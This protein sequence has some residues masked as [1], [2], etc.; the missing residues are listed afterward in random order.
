ML[1]LVGFIV[2]VLEA[3]YIDWNL[4]GVKK[5]ISLK[6]LGAI[7]AVIFKCDCSS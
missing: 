2:I 6:Q 3:G 1:L 4:G 5:I 7:Y